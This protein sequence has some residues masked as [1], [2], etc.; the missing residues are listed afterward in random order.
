MTTS[1]QRALLLLN[2]RE[3]AI[4]FVRGFCAGDVAALVPLLAE[5]F[6]F[7]GPFFQFDSPGSYLDALRSDPPE[8]ARYKLL[9]VTESAD[10][11]SIYYDYE[12][13]DRVLTVAQL[14]KFKNQKICEML[15]VFDGRGFA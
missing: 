13:S 11:V 10:S 15:V 3:V 2:N 7:S 9:S 14:F 4:E 5:D 12:K 1:C 6:R 8:A